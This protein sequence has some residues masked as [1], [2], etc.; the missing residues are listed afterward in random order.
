[1]FEEGRAPLAAGSVLL[2]FAFGIYQTFTLAFLVVAAMAVARPA[3][4]GVS[5]STAFRTRVLRLGIVFVAGAAL[6]AA[7]GFMTRWI[8]RPSAYIDVYLN[9]RDFLVDF[10]GAAGRTLP[11]IGRLLGCT[12]AIFLRAGLPFQILGIAGVLGLLVDP[13]LRRDDRS[14]GPLAVLALFVGAT[15]VA[16]VP[17]VVAAG[18]APARALITLPPLYAAIAARSARLSRVRWP[19]WMVLALAAVTG[20]WISVTL[21]Y[22]DDIARQRDALTASALS[23]RIDEVGR[24]V[25]P[26]RIPLL[27]V[28]YLKHD[29]DLA[30]RRVEVFGTSFFEHDEGNPYRIAHYL[31]LMGVRDLDPQPITS[32]I[33]IAREVEA[34]PRW[35]LPGSVA[36]VGGMLVVKFGPP[37]TPQQRQLEVAGAA[38][39]GAAGH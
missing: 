28:G 34:M 29:P 5:R 30:L 13:W 21:F 8:A 14:P 27:V 36:V 35:P 16:V 11:V 2:A 7:V 22:S 15:A 39:A 3:P 23:A 10:R 26:D 33:P 31:R 20:V 32:L 17:V 18:M 38:A 12:H 37:S 4:E 25:F 1:V 6:Y 9:W 24:P 19:Q